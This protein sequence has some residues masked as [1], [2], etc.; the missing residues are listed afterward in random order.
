M[1]QPT[2]KSVAEPD[3]QMADYLRKFA[4]GMEIESS[5]RDVQAP[6][7]KKRR[8][9]DDQGAP[10]ADRKSGAK[11]KKKSKEVSTPSGV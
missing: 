7:S 10:Q 8:R 4:E 5:T 9:D 11:K 1:S 3:T 2:L 6:E